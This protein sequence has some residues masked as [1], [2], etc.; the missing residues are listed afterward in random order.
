[1][2]NKTR[3][4]LIARSNIARKEYPCKNGYKFDIEIM[5]DVNEYE[6]CIKI[7]IWYK[8]EIIVTESSFVNKN[9]RNCMHDSIINAE[10]NTR[11]E[12]D[13]I[14][15]NKQICEKVIEDLGFK[16]L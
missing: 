15:L 5:F 2:K 6:D 13:M 11:N 3:E 16:Y 4:E 7:T 9:S 14:C 8:N 1:M 12:V 10:I